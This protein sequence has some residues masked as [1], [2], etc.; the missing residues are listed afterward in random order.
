MADPVQENLL[1]EI[2]EDLRRE[3]FETLWKRYGSW[4]IGAAIAVVLAVAAFQ[5]WRTW[6]TSR[7]EARSA[8]FIAAE[9]LAQTDPA[10][11]M[12]AFAALAARGSDGY[13][14]LAG[15]REAALLAAQGRRDEA[16]VTY[17]RI[18]GGSSEPLYRDLATLR[19]VAIRLGAGASGADLDTLATRLS[20]LSED[21]NPWRHSA[22]ELSAAL[23]LQRGDVTGARELYT[24]LRDDVETPQGIRARAGEMI[25]RLG[26]APDAAAPEDRSDRSSARD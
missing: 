12:D 18:A 1:R 25:A 2:Q 5:A 8:D 9:T 14:M 10:A 22:R 4:L 11:A 26:P 19:A 13:A 20:P 15:F 23:A 17:D 21:S 3:K 7:R 16:A 24:K 6:E